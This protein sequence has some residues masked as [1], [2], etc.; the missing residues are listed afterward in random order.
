MHGVYNFTI[1]QLVN[2]WRQLTQALLLHTTHS[3]TPVSLV[4]PSCIRV[5]QMHCP[6]QLL[7]L[8]AATT[9]HHI[10][11]HKNVPYIVFGK[12]KGGYTLYRYS[13]P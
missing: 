4:L 8:K 13:V 12:H 2:Y 10:P 11:S 9:P 7:R 1:P 6:I 3:F 5:V